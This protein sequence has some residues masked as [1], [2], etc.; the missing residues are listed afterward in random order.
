M[1]KP[2]QFTDRDL[3]TQLKFPTISWSSMS[4]FRDYDKEQWYRSYVL[5]ERTPPNAVMQG[6]IDVGSR[7]ILDPLFLPSIPRPEVFEQQL[8]AVIWDIRIT[9]HLDGFSPSVPCIDEYK[10]SS[11]KS[12]WTQAKVDNWGQLTFYCLLVY[13]HYSIKPETLKLRLFSIPMIETGHFEVIQQGEPIVFETKRTLLDVLNFII[14]IK[15]VHKE[16][17]EYIKN[18]E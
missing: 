8:S 10:T 5:G 1:K 12:R 15:H 13:L 2:T 4:Q 14:E 16:M 17:L 11:N 9:G 7:I 3:N 18:H 6:G